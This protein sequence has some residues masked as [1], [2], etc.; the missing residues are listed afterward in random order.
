MS[1]NQ[2]G[3]ILDAIERLA[4]NP[5]APGPNVTKLRGR[6]GYRLRVGDW[7]VIFDHAGDEIVVRL[8]RPRGDIYKR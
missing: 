7:R 8:V 3:R 4:G 5:Q 6:E 1:M 2:A